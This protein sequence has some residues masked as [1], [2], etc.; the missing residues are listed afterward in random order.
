VPPSPP[1]LEAPDGARVEGGSADLA[2][3]LAADLAADLAAALAD[4]E[5]VTRATTPEGERT[6]PPSRVDRPRRAMAE[7]AIEQQLEQRAPL[8]AQTTLAEI[9]E[10]GQKIPQSGEKPLESDSPPDRADGAPP[11]KSPP[12]VAPD[13]APDVA[14]DVDVPQLTS[15]PDVAARAS[16][17]AGPYRLQFGAYHARDNAEGMRARVPDALAARIVAGDGASGRTLYYVRSHGFAT[18]EAAQAALAR[19][20]REHKLESFVQRDPSGA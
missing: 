5:P 1:A 11:T 10:P 14:A 16:T 19:A 20:A 17:D 3:A 4:V 15:T 13:V 7:D 6:P 8:V 12:E 18:R 9:A 2:A